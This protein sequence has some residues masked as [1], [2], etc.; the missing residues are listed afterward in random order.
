MSALYIYN[1]TYNIS[2]QLHVWGACQVYVGA[3]YNVVS[4]MLSY[5][6]GNTAVG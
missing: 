6:I 1:Y 4:C 5:A 3:E 2:M